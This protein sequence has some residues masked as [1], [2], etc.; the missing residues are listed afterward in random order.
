MSVPSW[1]RHLCLT[2]FQVSPLFH[3]SLKICRSISSRYHL[4]PM[5]VW[6]GNAHPHLCP[7][8]FPSRYTSHIHPGR[9]SPQ[10]R[11]WSLYLTLIHVMSQPYPVSPK[12]HLYQ[13]H[14]GHKLIVWIPSMSLLTSFN[15]P[16][17]TSHFYSGNISPPSRCW[18]LR[19]TSN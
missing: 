16:R 15:V 12:L 4:T 10:C 7:I 6:R 17:L 11:S 8:S 14:P 9:I 19:L 13:L 1:C 2:S 18:Y 5:Q 3:K